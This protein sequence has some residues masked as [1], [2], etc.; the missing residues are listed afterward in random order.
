MKALATYLLIFNYEM[1]RLKTMRVPQEIYEKIRDYRFELC[2]VDLQKSRVSDIQ[3][4]FV[5][6]SF[7]TCTDCGRTCYFDFCCLRNGGKPSAI[8]CRCSTGIR[9]CAGMGGVATQI[10]Y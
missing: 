4:V 6:S 3:T 2:K 5:S 10:Y 1:Y 7:W 8:G 9:I